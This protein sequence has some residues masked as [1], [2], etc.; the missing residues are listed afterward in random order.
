M[1]FWPSPDR[2]ALETWPREWHRFTQ[3]GNTSD[4][5]W[6]GIHPSNLAFQILTLPTKW[7]IALGLYTEI[8]QWIVFMYIHIIGNHDWHMDHLL[9][10]K[11]KKKIPV[12]N[13][14]LQIIHPALVNTPCVSSAWERRG[15][16]FR[17]SLSAVACRVCLKRVTQMSQA[18]FIY[19][20][21]NCCG[22]KTYMMSNII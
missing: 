11:K 6:P 9:Q 3:S 7:A 4:V 8:I 5:T 18:W 10:G 2:F 17:F 16:C 12:I 20:L 1:E 21:G 13:Y 15:L 19:I 22:K 14:S